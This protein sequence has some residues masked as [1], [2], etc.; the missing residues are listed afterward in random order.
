MLPVTG[1]RQ[2]NLL[3]EKLQ[4]LKTIYIEIPDPNTSFVLK[5]FRK[6]LLSSVGF[7]ELKSHLASD[8]KKSLIPSLKSWLPDEGKRWAIAK[9]E[10]DAVV[11][12]PLMQNSRRFTCEF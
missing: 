9:K 11:E 5:K 1:L 7:A 3:I 6:L 4:T 8:N 12:S 2:W 10:S